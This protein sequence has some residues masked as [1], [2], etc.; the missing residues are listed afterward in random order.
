MRQTT[1]LAAPVSLFATL[2]FAAGTALA[3]SCVEEDKACKVLGFAL[4][5]S[6]PNGAALHCKPSPRT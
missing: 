1:F 5:G 4:N 3:H 6:E 2:T